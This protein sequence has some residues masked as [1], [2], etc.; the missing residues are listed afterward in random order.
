VTADPGSILDAP[1]VLADPHSPAYW[2]VRDVLD[3][4]PSTR[5]LDWPV[6]SELA[7]RIADAGRKA[8]QAADDERLAEQNTEAFDGFKELLDRPKVPAY[9]REAVPGWVTARIAADA[10]KEAAS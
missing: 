8:F 4:D 1:Q 7:M 10:E 2:A 5:H 9:V 3:T 6:L